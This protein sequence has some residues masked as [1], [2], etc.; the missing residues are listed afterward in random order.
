MQNISQTLNEA[1]LNSYEM[2]V[3]VDLLDRACRNNQFGVATPSKRDEESWSV[4]NGIDEVYFLDGKCLATLS[5][6]SV[7]FLYAENNA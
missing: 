1:E 4:T 6:D 2:G 5:Q 7:D 3:M